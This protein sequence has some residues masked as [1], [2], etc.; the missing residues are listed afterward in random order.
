MNAFDQPGLRASDADRDRVAEQ[1][2]E[3][4]AEGRLTPD[5]HA[6]RLDAVYAAKTHGE[7][8]PLVADL[9]VRADI[10]SQNSVAPPPTEIGGLSRYTQ[11]MV[12]VFGNAKRSGRWLVPNGMVATAVFG[13]VILDLR[14]AVLERNEISVTANAVFGQV[15]LKVPRGVV[16][17]DEG[18]AVFGNRSTHQPAETPVAGAPVIR[19]K[20]ASI[21]GQLDVQYPKPH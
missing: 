19:V 2:R 12:A 21:F 1:L 6:E 8:A 20:G 14:E 11:P 18:V 16:V 5:E 17:L 4:F 9:P 7:L 13:E 3:A 15:V 10:A